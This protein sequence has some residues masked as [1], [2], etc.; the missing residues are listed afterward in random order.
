M[1]MTW[2]GLGCVRLT[3]RG[4]PAVVTEPFEARS[5]GLSLPRARADIVTFSTLI[6]DPTDKRWPGLHGVSR[7]VAA[8]GEYEIG[9]VFITG[10]PSPR[11]RKRG[12]GV[13]ENIV[14]TI[15]FGGVVVCHLG[16]LGRPPSQQQV[17]QFGRVD[18]LLVP[19]GIPGALTDAMASETVSLI[20]PEIVVPIEYKIPGLTVN[21]KPVAGFLKEMGV[22]EATTL[23]SLRISSGADA[24]ETQIVLL[25]PH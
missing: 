20:G 5:V 19:V 4:F 22:A 1:E 2:Y 7:T 10:V 12:V 14:Y 3:E 23:S 15:A 9:G 18:V 8:P 25:E 21:R 11:S 16:Q 13:G 6:D 24:E 17:E